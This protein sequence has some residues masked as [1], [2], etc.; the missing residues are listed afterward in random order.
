MI[1]DWLGHGVAFKGLH[2][3]LKRHAHGNAVTEELWAAL[4]EE[5]GKHVG[6]LARPWTSQCGY[7]YVHVK[8]TDESAGALHRRSLRLASGRHTPAWAGNPEAWPT[9]SDFATGPSYEAAELAAAAWRLPG[10][11]PDNA[12]WSIPLSIVIE[13]TAGGAGQER[14]LE[15]LD[16]GN[17]AG[18]VPAPPRESVLAAS[19]DA[20]A[21]VAADAHSH[22]FKLNARHAAFFRTVYDSHL[23]G[24]LLPALRYSP[25]R[26]SPPALSSIDRLGLVGD[27]WAGVQVGMTSATDLLPVLWACRYDI[28]YNVWVAVAD[29]ATGLRDAAEG[30]SP[31]LG[32]AIERFT[33]A[34]IAPVVEYVGW[35]TRPGTCFEW[36]SVVVDAPACTPAALPAG[37][38]PNTPLL[39]ALVLRVAALCGSA[40]VIRRCLRLFDEAET[41]I[42]ADLRALV[43]NTTAAEGGDERWMRL[44]AMVKSATSSEEQRRVI[45]ALGRAKSPALLSSAL[46]MLLGE[47]YARACTS[48]ENRSHVK[49]S[50]T[51]GRR[52]CRRRSAFAGRR[53]CRRCRRVQPRRRG[54]EPSMEVSQGKLGCDTQA[55]WRR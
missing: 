18:A 33:A 20:I 10:R 25:D 12:D 50:I 52:H 37:E 53:I 35:E 5:S 26:A 41:T 15:V 28:D 43:Y 49:R 2:T 27:V 11:T 54:P 32:S 45:G 7:P 17:A 31:E 19:A 3:Y 55:L 6:G 47:S 42:P 4:E 14:R 16:L 9:A 48:V 51:S 24:R 8:T 44:R 36:G 46:D 38:H 22:W 21:D 30:V 1:F 40:E 39:R 13:G 29:A 23:I 34:L